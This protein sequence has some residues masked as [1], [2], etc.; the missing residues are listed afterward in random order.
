MDDTETEIILEFEGGAVIEGKQ[1]SDYWV[2]GPYT[3][4]ADGLEIVRNDYLA[5]KS[6]AALL[7]VNKDVQLDVERD[8]LPIEVAI[9][10]KPAIATYLSGVHEYSKEDI[11]ELL[12]VKERTVTKYLGRFRPD[13]IRV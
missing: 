9:D 8:L 4:R 6:L 10:G 12:D 1:L 5:A 11:S 7:D 13:R 3:I 2:R